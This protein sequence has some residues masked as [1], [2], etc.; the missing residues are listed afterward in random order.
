MNEY[1][2]TDDVVSCCCN[3]IQH[4]CIKGPQ[5][6]D[7]PPCF[8]APAG[9]QLQ[10]HRQR[11]HHAGPTHPAGGFDPLIDGG[12]D[13]KRVRF[14]GQTARVAVIGGHRATDEGRGPSGD[15]FG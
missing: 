3:K 2:G 4:E 8:L 10:F 6:D 12:F 14:E 9:I 7:N 1:P 15:A 5:T 13:Q 11:A